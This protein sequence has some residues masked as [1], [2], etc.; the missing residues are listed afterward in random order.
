MFDQKT[1]HIPFLMRVSESQ[2][3]FQSL[4]KGVP[5]GPDKALFRCVVSRDPTQIH[6]ASGSY[7]FNE[8]WIELILA[9]EEAMAGQGAVPAYCLRK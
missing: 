1:R 2:P 7:G 4:N 9:V 8:S 3:G 5:V 6:E